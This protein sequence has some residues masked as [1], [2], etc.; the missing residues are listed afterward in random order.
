MKWSLLAPLSTAAFIPLVSLPA[1]AS[2]L[3]EVFDEHFLVGA[4]IGYSTLDAANHPALPV[5]EQH[6]HAITPENAMKW[7]RINPRPDQYAFQAADAFVDYGSDHDL[8]MVGHVLFWH[9]QTPDWVFEDEEG[10]PL[11]R[12]ALLARMRER[13]TMMAE[14]YGNRV[15]LWDVVNESIEEDGSWRRSKFQQIIGDDFTEQAFRIAAEV[16]PEDAVLLYNDYNMTEPG[17]RD[18]VVRMVK[19]FQAKGVRI[20]G[21]GIQGHWLMDYPSLDAIEAALVAFASTG[22]PVHITELDLDLLGRSQ[23]FGANVDIRSIRVSPENNPFPDGILPP[24]EEAR[25]A[26]RYAD[27]FALM[28]RHADKIDRVTFWGVGDADSWLNHFPVRGRTNF[29][30]LFDRNYEPKPAFYRVLEV[31]RQE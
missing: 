29:A 24:A 3:K 19:D 20:D 18:A 9:S 31:G 23:F 7:E 14:R 28:V 4:T 21:I 5:V 25:F 10:E 11:G 16:F 2:A 26:R 12:E 30:L 1:T 22:L 8:E 27:L 15:K 6:F 13:A 17:R